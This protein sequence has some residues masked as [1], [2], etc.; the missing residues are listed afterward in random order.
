MKDSQILGQG[1]SSTCENRAQLTGRNHTGPRQWLAGRNQTGGEFSGAGPQTF[2]RSEVIGDTASGT[3]GGVGNLGIAILDKECGPPIG[4]RT[5][6]DAFGDAIK[7]AE[8]PEVLQQGRVKSLGGS[9]PSDKS[10]AMS[11]SMSWL[12]AAIG[13]QWLMVEPATS[14]APSCSTRFRV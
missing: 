3:G 11:G 14:D 6:V 10:T 1:R 7:V 8:P 13:S 2:A 5:L 4:S 9:T 12:G